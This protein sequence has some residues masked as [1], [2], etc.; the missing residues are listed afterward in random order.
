[1]PLFRRRP[2]EA[3]NL[4]KVAAPPVPVGSGVGGGWM[5]P[6]GELAAME[7]QGMS[8]QYP[9]SPGAPIPAFNAY[10]E[11]PRT[12]DFTTGRNITARPRADEDVSFETL[13]QVIRCYDFAKICVRHRIDDIISLDYTILPVDE[14]ESNVDVAIAEASRRMAKPDGHTRFTP[15]LKKYLGD[16][17]RFD[18]GCLYRM[19]DHAER[20]CGLKVIDGT[21]IVPLV[22][23]YG[24][25]PEPDAP[26]F[27]QFANGVPWVPLTAQDVIYEPMW[28]KSESAYGE[29]P[30]EAILMRV[31]TDVRLQMKFLQA[32]TEGTLPAG[33]MEAPADTTDPDKIAEFQSRWDGVMR[34]DQSKKWD[35]RWVPAGSKFT[36]YHEV[37]FD[38][39]FPLFLM[40]VCAAAFHVVPADLGFTETVNK[41]SGDTQIDVQF[42]TGTLPLIKH[43]QAILD[44]YLQVDLGLPVI[45]RFDVGAEKEDRKVTADAW[46]VAIKNGSASPD[47]YREQVLG[48]KTDPSRPTPRFIYTQR[49][50][51]IPLAALYAASGELDRSTF[52]PAEGAELPEY[53]FPGVEGVLANPMPRLPSLSTASYDPGAATGTDD[54]EGLDDPLAS[55][56]PDMAKA[57]AVSVAG[58]CVKAAD[59]GRVLLL[60]RG[61][62]DTTD[63]ARGCWEFP[64][65]HL[66]P[67][68][69]PLDGALR[70]W[71]EEIG[72]E[73]PAGELC[74]GWVSPNGVYQGFVWLI[75][76]ES[77]ITINLP[78]T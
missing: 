12:W 35:V 72:L 44:D 16:I 1:M 43:V 54:G 11:P 19:R 48:L 27:V 75:P 36:P 51:V 55:G 58:L 34:G 70:E 63:P 22:D 52:A 73:V 65:G 61:F 69:T 59:T 78:K 18:A 39:V 67:G 9:F 14:E 6:P 4:A 56:R 2:T 76:H 40:H 46:D 57:L 23:Y 37:A 26:A 32:F 45:G 8:S 21:S 10:G 29:P 50:G 13:R 77:D 17:L 33:F 15:W 64:G 41:S 68:E 71:C 53:P 24:D 49:G 42:R 47:E 74:D 62:T 66:E 20:V 7:R 25:T 38:D 60:Q 30:V 31:N 3:P 28:P 5:T